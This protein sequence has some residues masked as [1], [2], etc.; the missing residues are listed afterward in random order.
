MAAQV[1]QERIEQVIAMLKIAGTGP[2]LQ[3]AVLRA[4][5]EQSL[6]VYGEVVDLPNIQ[7]VLNQV[8]WGLDLWGC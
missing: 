6:F 8:V 4:L 3:D 7:Q 5:A 1:E 2:G